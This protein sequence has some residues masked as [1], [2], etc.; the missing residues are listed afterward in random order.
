MTQR[1][2]HNKWQLPIFSE[3]SD[4]KCLHLRGRHIE[5]YRSTDKIS[6]LNKIEEE[7]EGEGK[8]GL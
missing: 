5:A 4:L 7:G 8:S 6:E 1:K 3:S 2:D